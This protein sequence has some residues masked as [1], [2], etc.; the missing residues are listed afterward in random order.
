MKKFLISLSLFAIIAIAVPV[1][2]QTI[3]IQRGDTLTS[4]A[5]EYGTT[6]SDLARINNIVDPN[7]IYAG[8][9]LETDMLGVSIPTVVAVYTDSLASRITSSATTFTLVRGT[10]KQSRSLSGF[11]GFV[12]DEGTTSEEF[13]TANCIATACTFVSRGIDVQDGKTEVAGNKQPHNRAATVKITN[14]PQLAILSRILNGQESASSTFSFGDGT[15]GDFKCLKADNGSTDLPSI[16]YDETADNWIFSDNGTDTTVLNSL[17]SGGLTASSTKGISIT[18]SKIGVHVNATSSGLWFDSTKDY[19]L[20]INTSSTKY[21]AIDSSGK[22]YLD[23]TNIEVPTPIG[24]NSVVPKT[25][26]DS[27][28]YSSAVSNYAYGTSG[29][30]IT[31]GQPVYVSSTNGYL[32]KVDVDIAY[33]TANYVGISDSTV[34]GAGESVKY[35]KFGGIIEGLSGYITGSALFA[36]STAGNLGLTPPSSGIYA[37]LAV[38]LSASSILV[39]QPEYQNSGVLSNYN[40]GG[41]GGSACA[42]LTTSTQYITTGFRPNK[43]TFRY[44]LQGA[45]YNSGQNYSASAGVAV[46]SGERVKNNVV[47]GT[48]YNTVDLSAPTM[49]IPSMSGASLPAAGECTDETGENRYVSINVASTTETGFVFQLRTRADSS[50]DTDSPIRTRIS[51][52]A[53]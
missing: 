39:I 33:S 51:W 46:F 17:T 41:Y 3:T 12:F 15:T 53:E 22:L 36:S 14:F 37:K 43:I 7:R 27:A 40:G 42:W 11:Y 20:S 47:L 23:T 44:Y 4:I 32:Y 26:V 19:P 52:E 50:S 28:A 1:F 6:V 2:A 34:G 25:Y 29:E 48:Y 24:D 30:A 16:C 5:E 13:A 38:V 18:D 35:A 10:D 45:D 9:T 31:K 8:A 21:L 49:I